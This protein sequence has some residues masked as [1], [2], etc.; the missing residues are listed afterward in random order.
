MGGMTAVGDESDKRE[1]QVFNRYYHMFAKGELRRL[2]CEAADELQLSVG[3]ETDL[4]KISGITIVQEGWEKS[5][6]Y[7]EIRTWER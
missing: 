3:V 4:T 6:Y 2:I 7:V 5:N 1:A